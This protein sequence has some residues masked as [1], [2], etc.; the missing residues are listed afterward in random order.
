MPATEYT[1]QRCPV[2]SAPVN[3]PRS[4]SPDPSNFDH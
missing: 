4:L 3:M 2:V 1:R